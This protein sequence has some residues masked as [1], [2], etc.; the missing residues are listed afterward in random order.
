MFFFVNN[1]VFVSNGNLLHPNG[2]GCAAGGASSA[3]LCNGAAQQN[4]GNGDLARSPG[5]A[6]GACSGGGGGG[7]GGGGAD[8]K[9]SKHQKKQDGDEGQM[10]PLPTPSSS[11]KEMQICPEKREE[12]ENMSCDGNRLAHENMKGSESSVVHGAIQKKGRKNAEERSGEGPSSEAFRLPL[13]LRRKFFASSRSSSLDNNHHHVQGRGRH[14]EMKKCG[15]S[16]RLRSERNNN[17]NDVEDGGV[18]EDEEGLEMCL[19]LLAP[20]DGEG[21]VYAFV[22]ESAAEAEEEDAGLLGLAEGGEETLV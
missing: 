1:V 12:E 6:Q 15:G 11:S 22:N 10:K 8:K 13:H 4:N 2:N 21:T 9:A 3:Q 7:G 16:L 20:A 5:S 19:Q 14:K 17:N 18:H